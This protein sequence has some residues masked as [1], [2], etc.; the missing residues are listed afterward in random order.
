MTPPTPPPP[1]NSQSNLQFAVLHHT[2]GDSPNH[3]D[4]LIEQEPG[5]G[6]LLTYRLP[7]W[8]I[9]GVHDVTR[10][11]NHRRL[12]LTYQG[13]LAGGKGT[14][15]QVDKGLAT[16]EAPGGFIR[17]I[18]PTGR[19]LEFHPDHDEIWTLRAD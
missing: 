10:L 15:T 3:F 18:L 16:L 6:D 7:S 4:F 19:A 17:I 11:R 8:P 5:Q 2:G 1:S 13:E 9:S 14:V 12:Y